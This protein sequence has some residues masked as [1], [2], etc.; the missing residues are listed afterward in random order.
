M[1][2]HLVIGRPAAYHREPVAVDLANPT[3]LVLGPDGAMYVSSRFEGHVY[4]LMADDRVELFASEL[5]VATGLAFDRHGEREG[6][7][8]GE[9]GKPLVIDGLW[10]LLPGNGTS[11]A[12]SDVWFSAGPGGESHGLLGIL[13]AAD[14]D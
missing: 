5:G 4:R 1:R 9:D 3:S 7:L 11:G 12:R 2:Q 13:R 6:T 14:D 10:G 8:R